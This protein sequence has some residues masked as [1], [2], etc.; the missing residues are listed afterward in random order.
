MVGSTLERQTRRKDAPGGGMRIRF[1]LTR[2]ARGGP[3]MSREH[4]GIA[5]NG[6]GGRWRVIMEPQPFSQLIREPP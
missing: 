2:M 6:T 3:M 1:M 5:E 4:V